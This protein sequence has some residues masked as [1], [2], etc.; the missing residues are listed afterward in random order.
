MYLS[1]CSVHRWQ[2]PL[3]GSSL[4]I[5]RSWLMWKVGTVSPFSASLCAAL[6]LEQ[7][8]DADDSNLVD[9]VGVK[10]PLRT[11]LSLQHA[12]NKLRSYIMP[13]EVPA[14]G[15]RDHH[16]NRVQG[17]LPLPSM[18]SVLNDSIGRLYRSSETTHRNILAPYRLFEVLSCQ[19]KMDDV[20]Q[21]V[22]AL[23]YVL[24][25]F[26]GY[27]IYIFIIFSKWRY[28]MFSMLV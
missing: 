13:P 8:A 24:I 16:H 3:R 19:D 15:L 26:V 25:T 22:S 9:N 23:K 17:A 12:S 20:K 18:S 28:I 2:N 7:L 5:T 4:N 6:L 10:L 14:D 21:W 27:K 1:D 11:G